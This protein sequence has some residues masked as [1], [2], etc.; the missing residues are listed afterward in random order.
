[1]N[2]LECIQLSLFG[3]YFVEKI[4]LAG[5]FLFGGFA[6]TGTDLWAARSAHASD[7]YGNSALDDLLYCSV[8]RLE[9]SRGR[10]CHRRLRSL[11]LASSSF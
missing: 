1:M 7:H 2:L 10:R 9:A 8:S 6:A 4:L 5:V 3:V 11:F